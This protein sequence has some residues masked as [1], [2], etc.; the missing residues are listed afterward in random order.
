[1]A[2][3]PSTSGPNARARVQGIF[4]WPIKKGDPRPVDEAFARAGQGLDGD[5]K[6][7]AKRQLTLLNAEDWA[8]AT[9]EVGSDAAPMW[10]RANVVVSG[11]SFTREM[12]GRRLRLG[13]VR[14][15]IRG[16][17]DPC[18]RMDDVHPGLRKALEP[19]LRAGVYGQIEEEGL[20][21]LGDEIALEDDG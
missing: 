7:S 10:R 14:L 20:L 19:D 12:I 1:M 9:R 3:P 8:V 2:K 13:P 15:L 6:R 21:R 4:L 17:T 5:R 18:H 11:F 16:E